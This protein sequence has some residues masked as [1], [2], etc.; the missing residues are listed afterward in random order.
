MSWSTRTGTSARAPHVGGTPERNATP[1]QTSI[2]I[3]RSIVIERVV[4]KT[5]SSFG[6]RASLVSCRISSSTRIDVLVAFA[7]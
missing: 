6:K 5:K 2:E 1:T 7:K 4:L 3:T